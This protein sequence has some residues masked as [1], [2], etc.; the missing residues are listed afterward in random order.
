VQR[1]QVFISYSHKDKKWRDDLD[2]H[3]KPYL[4]GGSV[5]SWSDKQIV[6][7]SK[8]FGE[9][10]SALVQTN[11][12]V[13]LVTPAFVASDFIHEHE[14][15]PLLKE[16]E[17]GGVTI[18]WVPIYASAYKQTALEKYQAVLDPNKPLGSFSKAK[19]DEAWVKICEEIGK[20]VNPSRE[21]IRQ[22]SL[23][24][25]AAQSA[26]P[27]SQKPEHP[28]KREPPPIPV[29][30]SQIGQYAPANLSGRKSQ[31][32][33]L[34][35]TEKIVR[36]LEIDRIQRRELLSDVLR[37][38]YE[39]LQEIHR[40]YLIVLSSAKANLTNDP[41]A[42][43]WVMLYLQ[44]KRILKEPERTKIIATCDRLLTRQWRPEV[45]AFLESVASYFNLNPPLQELTRYMD[46]WASHWD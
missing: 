20:A 12:A 43:K 26:P 1:D 45:R 36:L 4:R 6:P 13:L 27:I 23:K 5:V 30:I 9:I 37:P 31:L 38:I 46:G 16:A 25:A 33:T 24:H 19:R 34:R 42:L 22:D 11:V 7:G 2:T 10:Q 17:R 28:P 21:P 14:L 3:L 29:D 44:Q 15:G 41:E 18:L 39:D 35:L 40:D 8:W 32:E